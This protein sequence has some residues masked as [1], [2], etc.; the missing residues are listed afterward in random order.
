[1]LNTPDEREV[2]RYMFSLAGPAGIAF[3]YSVTDLASWENLKLV[4]QNCLDTAS[5]FACDN[6]QRFMI[7]GCKCDLVQEREVDYVTVKQYADEKGFL[8]FELNTKEN[9]CVNLFS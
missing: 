7:V 8:F 9:A 3:L 6:S 2:A 4:M 1:M 5:S